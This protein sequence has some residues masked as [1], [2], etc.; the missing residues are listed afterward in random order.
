MKKVILAIG[1]VWLVGLSIVESKAFANCHKYCY[2]AMGSR[3]CE[4]SCF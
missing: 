3:Y 4:S 1:F 2:N